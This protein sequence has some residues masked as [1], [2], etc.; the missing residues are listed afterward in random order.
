MRHE[1]W[2]YLRLQGSLKPGQS[3][4]QVPWWHFMWGWGS[5]RGEDLTAL[6][7]AFLELRP[8]SPSA[9]QTDI[10]SSKSYRAKPKCISISWRSLLHQATHPRVHIQGCCKD[11]RR[12]QGY[13]ITQDRL[14][15][16]ILPFS[17]LI[18]WLLP[19]LSEQE[20]TSQAAQ[21]PGALHG[22]WER[23]NQLDWLDKAL[24]SQQSHY[25]IAT[26]ITL[27]LKKKCHRF[28]LSVLCHVYNIA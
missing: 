15:S 4:T 21:F 26:I 18:S 25:T 20:G 12:S 10:G 8:F 17:S 14:E 24:L 3:N 9:A 1:Q 28:Q 7:F 11:L 16:P 19:L 23:Q 6:L 13:Q 27:N 5:P 22:V 2:C